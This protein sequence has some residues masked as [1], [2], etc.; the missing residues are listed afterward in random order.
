MALR[1]F[2]GTATSWRLPSHLSETAGSDPANGDDEKTVYEPFHSFRYLDEQTFRF[3]TCKMTDAQRFVQVG[4]TIVGKRLTF[5]SLT[6]HNL[7]ERYP[8]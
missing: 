8:C 1:R 3:N 5:D 6:G 7:P 2:Y 4:R